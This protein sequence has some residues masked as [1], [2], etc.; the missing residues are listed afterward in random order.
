MRLIVDIKT[1]AE[2]H[3]DIA[4][5]AKTRRIALN[6]T[7][8]ELSS[9]SGVA[10]ATL[11]RFEQG[12]HASLT[13]V[14]TVAECLNALEEFKTLFPAPEATTLDEI[15]AFATSRQRVRARK[16]K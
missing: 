5:A 6:I 1:A 9:R 12:G 8:A 10:I 15:E 16:A 7:Q 3:Q 2:I 14:L 4:A 13:T 11:K